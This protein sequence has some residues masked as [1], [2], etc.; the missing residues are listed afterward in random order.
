M[1]LSDPER[2]M[3][4]SDPGSFIGIFDEPEEIRK[5][6]A[7]A[8]TATD[9]PEGQIPKGVKNLFNLFLELG[10]TDIHD[11]FTKQYQNGSIKYSELKAAL[12]DVIAD[13][14]APMRER[15]KELDHEAGRIAQV[16]ADGSA[17]ARAV[18]SKTMKE[19]KEKIGLI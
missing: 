19:V 7:K 4:K 8:V 2:K 17:S 13:Y 15:R 11:D 18:A 16:L 9:A 12:A 10:Q 6:L 5:K 14:F 1:S 3:S